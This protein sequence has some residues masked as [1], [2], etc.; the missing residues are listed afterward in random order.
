MSAAAALSE[1]PG[2]LEKVFLNTENEIAQSGIYAVNFHTLGL[3]HTV[4][5]DDYLPLREW[6]T[7]Y[8]TL[9]AHVGEDSGLWGPILE[10]AFAKYHG[11]YMHIAGGDP[12]I[13]LRTLSGAPYTD[14]YHDAKTIDEL[15]DAIVEHDNA[16]EMIQGGTN[17]GNDTQTNA[18]GLVLG[19]AYTVLSHAI[20]STGT[21]LVKLR[22]PW[23]SE[24][25]HGDWSKDSTLWTDALRAEVGEDLANDGFFFMSIENYHAQVAYTEFNMDTTDWHTAS[26]LKLGDNT[27]A[28][29]P[30]SYSWCGSSCTRHYL[31]LTSDVEQTVYVTAHTWDNRGVSKDCRISLGDKPHNIH[32]PHENYIQAFYGGSR[33]LTPF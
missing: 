19:H 24:S 17:G 25:F 20:L 7:G 10:K 18:D 3:P 12:A 32:V 4:V 23:A 28:E 5:I 2:R 30:G 6:G 21:R 26:F 14:F 22:N 13:A 15:W 29:N 8:K 33:Q 16:N 1:V 9:F 31:N 11:N 27:A